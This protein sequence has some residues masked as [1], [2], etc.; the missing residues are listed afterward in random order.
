MRK[1]LLI[2]IW[3][4]AI[5]IVAPSISAGD[6]KKEGKAADERVHLTDDYIIG[7]G[8]VLEVFVWRNEQLSRK[9]VVRPDGKVSLPLIQD[10]RAAGSTAIQLKSQITR[11]LDEYIDN[12]RVSVIVSEIRSYRVSVLGRVSNPGVYPISGNT[13]LVEAI[14][15]AGGFTEWAYKR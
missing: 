9:V 11:R 12:P 4:F 15:L 5:L 2:P 3:I 7:Q 1:A 13:T 6:W 14:S 8:D 10:L